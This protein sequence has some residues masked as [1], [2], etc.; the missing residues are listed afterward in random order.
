[1]IFDLWG[2]NLS[3]TLI[4]RQKDKNQRDRKIIKQMMMNGTQKT[5]RRPPMTYSDRKRGD[6]GESSR[7]FDLLN[8]MIIDLKRS[9]DLR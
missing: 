1:M 3:V 6:G 4:M 8:S 7:F 9:I 5:S 2:L